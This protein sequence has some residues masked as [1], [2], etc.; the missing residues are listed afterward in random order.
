MSSYINAARGLMSNALSIGQQYAGKALTNAT[1]SSTR[2][3]ISSVSLALIGYAG[4][5]NYAGAAIKAFNSA[6]T[7]IKGNDSETEGVVAKLSKAF[8]SVKP[9]LP[10][11][12]T[13]FGVGAAALALMASGRVNKWI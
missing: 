10:S 2:K 5:T 4:A 6:V 12:A 1:G 13:S 9:H 11:A 8:D 3:A 7:Y